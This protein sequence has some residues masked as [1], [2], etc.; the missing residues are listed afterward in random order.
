MEKF[1]IVQVDYKYCNYLRKFDLKV[2]FNSGLKRN[3]PFI[4]VLFKINNVLYFAPLSSPKKKHKTMKNTL[5][6]IKL[7]EGNL[8]AINFNNMIPVNKENY[9]I[10][11]INKVTNEKERQYFHLLQLQL[12][13]LNKNHVLIRNK[14]KKLYFNYIN[15]NLPLNIRN[16]CCNFKLL[17]EKCKDYI[18]EIV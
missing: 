14:A 18:A 1:I 16:R 12:I 8:G 9:Q 7:D 3:R 15:N 10:L 2:P 4:G 17:E 11:D 6:F 13:W 5:D